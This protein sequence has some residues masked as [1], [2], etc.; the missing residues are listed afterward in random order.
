[1]DT[2]EIKKRILKDDEG[3]N[4]YCLTFDVTDEIRNIFGV[5]IKEA[6]AI[7][8]KIY[9]FSIRVKTESRIWANPPK[10]VNCY[11]HAVHNGLE[12]HPESVQIPDMNEIIVVFDD[13]H[14]VSFWTSEWGGIKKKDLNAFR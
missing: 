14:T 9:E 5:P 13:D 12:I 6:F 3:K 2:K 10:T 11:R 4:I 8:Y 1:M 7:Y